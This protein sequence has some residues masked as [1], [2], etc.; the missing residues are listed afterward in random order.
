MDFHVM[1]EAAVFQGRGL[2]LLVSEGDGCV[3]TDGCRIRDIRGAVHVVERVTMQ[4]DL[5]CLFL[6]DADA[7]YFERMFRDVF[8]D[9][10]RF[11]L[12]EGET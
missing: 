11:T 3:F 8:V 6:R 7:E 1:D 4:E 2:T 5:T 10:T 9:A 12:L